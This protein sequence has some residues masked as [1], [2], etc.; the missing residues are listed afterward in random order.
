MVEALNQRRLGKYKY[1]S[2]GRPPGRGP[3]KSTEP[4][5]Q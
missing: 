3:Q 2:K 1:A 5:A 4:D